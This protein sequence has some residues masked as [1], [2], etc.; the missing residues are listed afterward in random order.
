MNCRSIPL[1]G[2][3]GRSTDCVR[4]TL[5]IASAPLGLS[6]AIDVADAKERLSVA[7][8]SSPLLER[9]RTDGETG[10]SHRA[11][12]PYASD[13]PRCGSSSCA[14]PPHRLITNILPRETTAGVAP[15]A[16]RFLSGC[17]P[18]TTLARETLIIQLG[19]LASL[20]ILVVSAATSA[21]ALRRSRFLEKLIETGVS[22]RRRDDRGPND[23][24][25]P[26]RSRW[27]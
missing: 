13:G 16:G 7:G 5:L 19:R 18:E 24:L 8:A 2:R 14:R 21:G 22:E 1:A 23:P 4:A 20:L 9:Y 11:E 25:N 15:K 3:Q 6:T 10:R 12:H 26:G 27:I 17:P